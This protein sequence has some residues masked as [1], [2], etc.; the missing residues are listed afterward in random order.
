MVIRKSRT[1]LP[2]GADDALGRQAGGAEMTIEPTFDYAQRLVA[3]EQ[4]NGVTNAPKARATVARRVR[5]GVGSLENILRKRVK[6]IPAL[7]RDRFEDALIGAIEGQIK[8]LEDELAALRQLRGARRLDP[9][10]VAEIETDLAA[11][12]E[13][14]TALTAAE[15][16]G[17]ALMA[18]EETEVGAMKGPQAEISASI[19]GPRVG[20]LRLTLSFSPAGADKFGLAERPRARPPWSKRFGPAAPCARRAAISK[21]SS[22][23]SMQNSGRSGWRPCNCGSGWTLM[24]GTAKGRA[25]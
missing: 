25:A 4:S 23:R 13:R 19:S 18:F 12:R 20:A 16:M 3:L 17:A 15:R 22:T 5:L 6:T 11:L 14:L 1:F 24:R 10:A 9:L 8:R 2:D 21:P 7:V